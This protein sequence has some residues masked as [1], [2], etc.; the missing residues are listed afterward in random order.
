MTTHD[1]LHIIRN[2]WGWSEEKVRQ[3]RIAAA[4]LIEQQAKSIAELT[5]LLNNAAAVM[6]EFI[7]RDEK[8]R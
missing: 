7:D 5:D 6:Q 2:P 8:R 4:D 3:A 1:I